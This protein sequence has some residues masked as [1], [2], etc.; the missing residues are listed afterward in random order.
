MLFVKE[1]KDRDKKI[2]IMNKSKNNYYKNSNNKNNN[3]LLNKKKLLLNNKHSLMF[4][5]K[6]VPNLYRKILV[7]LVLDLIE[8]LTYGDK[9]CMVVLRLIKLFLKLK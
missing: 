8:I 5:K 1:L 4:N 3:L 2:W 9:D 7:K 6:K